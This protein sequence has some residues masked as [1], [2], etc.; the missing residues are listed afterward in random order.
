MPE[1]N[2]S[3][4]IAP[5]SAQNV[6]LQ[7]F[8]GREAHG[9]R[10]LEGN[11]SIISGVKVKVEVV[12]GST[13]MTVGELFALQEGSVVGLEQL[14]DAPLVVRLE[15]RTIAR[16]SLVVVGDNFGIRLS[17]ILPTADTSAAKA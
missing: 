2:A 3:P 6:N 14:R 13:E 4:D 11:L 5:L 7:E 1:N 12:V 16:G 10:L 17:E 8:S 15:G 9:P